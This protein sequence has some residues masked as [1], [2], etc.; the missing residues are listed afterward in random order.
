M[1]KYNHCSKQLNIKSGKQHMPAVSDFKR[2]GG[3]SLVEVLVAM[4][5]LALLAL[6]IMDSFSNAAKLNAKARREENANIVAANV[7]EQFKSMTIEELM[8]ECDENGLGTYRRYDKYENAVKD[9][10]GSTVA[11]GPMKVT[12]YYVFTMKNTG[13][14]GEA[15]ETKVILNPEAYTDIS[16]SNTANNINSYSMPKYSSLNAQQNI[17]VREELYRTDVEALGNLGVSI[18]DA[19]ELVE[20]TVTINV[21]IEE[22]GIGSHNYS[23]SV[24]G[25][26]LYRKRDNSASVTKNFTTDSILIHAEQQ[27]DQYVLAREQG[28][29]NVYLFYMPFDTKSTTLLNENYYT[30][31]DQVIIRYDYP[32]EIYI[33]C[34]DCNVYLVEQQVQN[35]ADATGRHMALKRENVK[36]YINGTEVSKDSTGTVLLSKSMEPNGPVSIFSNIYGWSLYKKS[37]QASG[38]NGLSQGSETAEQGYL[39]RMTVEISYQ[40]ETYTT[41]TTTKEN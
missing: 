1:T 16:S 23:Q 24:R 10:G 32:E 9:E 41:I 29:K 37:D 11:S 21:V 22:S 35:T 2:N 40:G 30:A 7:A 38:N 17:L 3:F 12:D 8:K 15:F 27:G 36:L 5:I 39:Y 14:N 28:V 18:N 6:P 26:I 20:K 31:T 19:G 25:E 4:A 13:S 34:A 33:S